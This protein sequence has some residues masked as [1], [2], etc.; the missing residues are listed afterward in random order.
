MRKVLQVP[1]DKRIYLNDLKTQYVSNC[2]S[3]SDK[4]VKRKLFPSEENNGKS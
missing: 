4:V 3:T 2:P 1:G